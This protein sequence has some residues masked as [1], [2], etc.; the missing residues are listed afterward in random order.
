MTTSKMLSDNHKMPFGLHQGKAMEDVPAG[1]FHWLWTQKSFD[2]A[3]P[4]GEYI[5]ENMSALKKEDP[6][7]EWE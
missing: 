3:S 1:Y 6:D 7:K 4:V 5:K 2:K